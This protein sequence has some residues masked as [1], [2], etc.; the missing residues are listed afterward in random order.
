MTGHSSAEQSGMTESVA[1]SAQPIPRLRLSLNYFFY[2]AIM[3]AL[4]PYMAR[5]LRGEGLPVDR[6]GQVAA[7]LTLMMAIGP[8]LWASLS[9]RTGKRM[10]WAR[11]SAFM[12]F[13]C[14]VGLALTSAL[15]L[16]VI[17]IG[18]IGL[19]LASIVPQVEAVTLEYL[20]PRS[21]SYGS[22]RLWGTLGFAVAVMLLGPLLDWVGAQW[23][24]AI[25]ALIA[26]L[27]L[28]AMLLVRDVPVQLDAPRS[29]ASWSAFLARLRR[30]PVWGLY[31][32]L[33]FWNVGLAAYNTF[34]D[35]YLQGVGYSGMAIGG[36]LAVAPIAEVFLFM[37]L[38]V[39]LLRWGA[40]TVLT[41]ALLAT[42]GRWLL[43]AWAADIWWVLMLA[44][45]A[46]ALT[47]GALH[48]SAMYLLSRMF[49]DN[50]QARAQA[51][52]LAF[53]TGLGLVGGNLMA[54][55]MWEAAGGPQWVFTF[56]AA[57]SLV[58]MALVLVALKASRLDTVLR[59]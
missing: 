36:Y 32:A 27:S 8:F 18:A 21:S 50:Q 58:A 38:G 24:P 26:L 17:M 25:M 53:S 34:F 44:Q 42:A 41:I 3:G 19:F 13:L 14:F 57:V 22:I 5:Y 45:M 23:L 16:Q 35:L 31:L 1:Q 43:T 2:F 29:Q 28:G 49:P 47:Y 4:V 55:V 15:P 33:F 54:G 7:V 12:L 20:G 59:Q 56:S 52:Y 39:A 6:I 37:V 48:G 10:L 46:H 11:V 40:R 51:I 9:D 30:F